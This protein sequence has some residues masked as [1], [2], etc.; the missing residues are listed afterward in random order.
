MKIVFLERWHHQ[1]CD[2]ANPNGDN[3]EV[4]HIGM[5]ILM[6]CPAWIFISCYFHDTKYLSE[7]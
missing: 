7:L 2:V 1:P 4:Q 3:D 6:F 5:S